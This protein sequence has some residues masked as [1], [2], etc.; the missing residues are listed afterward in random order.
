MGFVWVC[1]IGLSGCSMPGGENREVKEY[2]ESRYESQEFEITKIEDGES[3]SY[4]VVPADFPEAAFTVEEGKIEE[5]QDWNYHDDYAACMLYGGAERLGLAYER[6]E[7]GYDVFITYEN[8][9]SIDETAEKLEQLVSDC[10]ESH[11]FDSLR[12]SCLITIKPGY[13]SNPVFPGYSIRI[14]TRYTYTVDKVFGIMAS[15]MIPGQLKEDLRFCHIYNAYQ[16]AIPRDSA[17][18]SQNDIDRYLEICSGAM[19]KDKDGNISVYEL[20]DGAESEL[21]FGGAYQILL[22]EGL[23]TEEKEDSFIASGNGITIEF[24]RTFDVSTSNKKPG[25]SCEIL[26]GEVD[27]DDREELDREYGDQARCAIRL[28]TDKKIEF[29]TPEKIASAAEEERLARLPLVQDAFSQAAAPGQMTSGAGMEV[30]VTGMETYE[31]LQGSNSSYVDSG[32]DTIWTRISIRIKNTGSTEMYLFPLRS[33]G[34]ESELVGVIADEEANLYRP[35]DIINL[36]LENIYSYQ[37]QAG[38]TVEG[39]IYIKLPRE[40]VAKE[41][42]LVL[43][44]FRGE[45]TV[46]SLLPAVK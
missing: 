10:L 38:D 7:S 16:Y 15:K 34:S 33:H 2:L 41:D 45:D 5:S 46:S 18:F 29:S 28:L 32:A 14:K 23:V 22:S 25:V 39:N 27:E 8:Y 13:E 31:R 40:L 1:L 30:T 26:S 37:L 3:V 36:G 44:M 20:V 43:W 6:G 4:R 17:V 21:S 12:C 42:A 11:A 35:T 24:F 9:L 19:G